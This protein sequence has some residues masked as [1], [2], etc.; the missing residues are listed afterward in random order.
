MLHPQTAEDLRQ[1]SGVGDTK[2][3]RYGE[4]FLETL[5]AA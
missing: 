4:A 3:A 5:R 1:V 2:L